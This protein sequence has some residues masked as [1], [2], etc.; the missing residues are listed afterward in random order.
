MASQSP[1]APQSPDE[2]E[3]LDPRL[4]A[5]AHKMRRLSLVSSG[6]M[7]L[8]I[9][10]VLGVVLYRSLSGPSSDGLVSAYPANITADEV[11]TVVVE[12]MPGAVIDGVSV[13][14]RSLFVS[15]SNADGPVILE[16]DRATWQIVS[17]VRF[18]E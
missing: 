16:I 15:V 1:N 4:E 3:P 18:G 10:A 12:S 5:V 2:E 14:A 17:T 7:F 6:I 8:G 13:D 11:R 9:I